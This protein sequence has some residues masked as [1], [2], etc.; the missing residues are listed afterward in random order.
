MKN[1]YGEVGTQIYNYVENKLLEKG[2]L[3]KETYA[4]FKFK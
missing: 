3:K 4:T 2:S 1:A